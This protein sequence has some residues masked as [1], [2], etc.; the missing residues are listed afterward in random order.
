MSERLVTE[1][2]C[3]CRGR[4]REREKSRVISADSLILSLHIRD[5]K[6]N[7]LT[8]Y[9]EFDDHLVPVLTYIRLYQTIYIYIYAYM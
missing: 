1:N 2:V 9:Y 7:V 4:E 3:V 5:I 6:Y 8:L